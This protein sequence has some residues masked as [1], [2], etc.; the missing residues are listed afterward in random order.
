MKY[1]H[2]IHTIQVLTLYLYLIVCLFACVQW[3]LESIHMLAKYYGLNSQQFFSTN[4]SHVAAKE[5]APA[6]P[7]QYISLIKTVDSSPPTL[8]LSA[9]ALPYTLNAQFHSQDA[10][11]PPQVDRLYCVR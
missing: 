11:A 9:A 2:K 4:N 10:A 6:P 7:T 1:T 3:S 5:G 8:L